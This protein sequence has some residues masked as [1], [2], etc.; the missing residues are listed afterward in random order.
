M[1]GPWGKAQRAVGE[2]KQFGARDCDVAE[3]EE[4][5]RSSPKALKIA[6]LGDDVRE[7]ATSSEGAPSWTRTKNLLIKSQLL[8]QL[9]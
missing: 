4:S 2:S 1:E 3:D 6:D 7:D 5:P 8:C 9:S